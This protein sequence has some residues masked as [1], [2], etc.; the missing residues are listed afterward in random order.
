MDPS[1]LPGNVK[2][3]KSVKSVEQYNYIIEVL[4]NWGDKAILKTASPDDPD[5]NA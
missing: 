5:A 1:L 4:T 2:R 3:Y